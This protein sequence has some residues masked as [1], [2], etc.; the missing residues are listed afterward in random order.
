M[1]QLSQLYLVFYAD[2]GN[3]QS[4]AFKQNMLSVF[5]INAICAEGRYAD[6]CG[7]R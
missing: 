3:V 2:C 4:A 6:C 1:L 7:T 5:M